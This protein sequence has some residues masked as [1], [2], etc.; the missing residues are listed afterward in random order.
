MKIAKKDVKKFI[1]KKTK[2]LLKEFKKI[3]KKKN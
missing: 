2:K 1:M 3:L